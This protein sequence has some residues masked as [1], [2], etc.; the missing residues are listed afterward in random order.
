MSE[1]R[2]RSDPVL[3]LERAAWSRSRSRTE[4]AKKELRDYIE[5]LER[6]ADSYQRE[7]ETK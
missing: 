5:Q 6:L 2:D 7:E 4:R 3:E 1:L